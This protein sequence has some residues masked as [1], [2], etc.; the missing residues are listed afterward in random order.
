LILPQMLKS[1][2]CKALFSLIRLLNENWSV[3]LR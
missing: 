2:T 3:T 1:H